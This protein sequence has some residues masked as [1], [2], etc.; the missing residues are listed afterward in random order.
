MHS[1]KADTI[2]YF[3]YHFVH[4]GQNRIET[5]AVARETFDS[6][7]YDATRALVEAE[8][9][10]VELMVNWTGGEPRYADHP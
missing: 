2:A 4:E 1:N 8:M 6:L 9:N 3:D 7:G 10:K 5:I